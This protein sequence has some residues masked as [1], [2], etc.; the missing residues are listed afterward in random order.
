MDG[1]GHTNTIEGVW[2][3]LKRAWY[4]QH[5][6]HRREFLPLNVAEACWKYNNRK[7]EE[8]F[9]RFV[10]SLF[11]KYIC[12]VRSTERI[13][14]AIEIPCAPASKSPRGDQASE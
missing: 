8:L 6:H 4:E 12:R 11:E 5:H 13:A 7:K 14:K 1:E 2:S 3:L 9:D 10:K